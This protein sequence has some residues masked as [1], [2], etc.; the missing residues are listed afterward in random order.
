MELVP[1]KEVDNICNDAEKSVRK[2]LASWKEELGKRREWDQVTVKFTDESDVAANVIRYSSGLSQ[3][4]IGRPFVKRTI[5]LVHDCWSQFVQSKTNDCKWVC[6]KIS[7]YAVLIIYYHEFSHIVRGHLYELASRSITPTAKF[8]WSESSFEPPKNCIRICRWMERDADVIAADLFTMFTL[9]EMFRD[10]EISI[11]QRYASL[12]LAAAATVFIQLEQFCR[13]QVNAV[14][15]HDAPHLRWLTY[16]EAMGGSLARELKLKDDDLFG[17]VSIVFKE[18]VKITDQQKLP[19]PLWGIADLGQFRKTTL[20]HTGLI[21]RYMI[22]EDKY[23]G[24]RSSFLPDVGIGE[25]D[26]AQS[27]DLAIRRLKGRS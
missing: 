12:C 7:E 14:V 21:K 24:D 17:A 5:R 22:N 26:S 3:I 2:H 16:I 1:N 23:L 11:R 6:R 10:V 27:I 9:L 15:I 19:A 8:C 25:V 20:K 4:Y 13:T 18:I